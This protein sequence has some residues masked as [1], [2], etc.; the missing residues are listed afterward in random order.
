MSAWMHF[1]GK[2]KVD[3]A[4]RIP[5]VT[6]GLEHDVGGGDVHVT[7]LTVQMQVVQSLQ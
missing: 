2:A 4:Q 6:V 3:E 5:G 7:N 1:L